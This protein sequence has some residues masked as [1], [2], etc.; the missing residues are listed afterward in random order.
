MHV[1]ELFKVENNDARS[2]CRGV[3][4]VNS[5]VFLTIYRIQSIDLQ[6]K[7]I[8]WFLCKW[9]FVLKCV[10]LEFSVEDTYTYSLESE[11]KFNSVKL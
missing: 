7:F 3:F 1:P 2:I 4:L 10:N 5:G 11:N 8:D 9:N 6:C